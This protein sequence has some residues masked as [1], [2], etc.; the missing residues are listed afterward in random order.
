MLV[1]LILLCPLAAI[2]VFGLLMSTGISLWRLIQ[3]DYGRNS[4]EEP[5]LKPALDTLYCLALLQ[6][7]LFCYSFLLARTK[8]RLANEVAAKCDDKED[9]E[10]V[11]NYLGKTRIGC[12]TDPSS[13]RGR[14]L[15]TH[16]VDLIG[17]KSPDDCRSGVQMLYTAIRIGERGLRDSRR[18]HGLGKMEARARFKGKTKEVFEQWE[19]IIGQHMLM[20]HLIMSADS[21]PLLQKLLEMLDPRGAYEAMTER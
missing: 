5:N 2:Y 11:S 8:K 3:H 18:V 12:E 15:I 16:G 21:S 1:L 17:S 13:A 20:K 19:E 4:T 7:V 10:I 9:L 14:N 6:G